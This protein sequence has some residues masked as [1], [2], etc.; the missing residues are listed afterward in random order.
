MS[1]LVKRLRR[2]DEFAVTFE[3]WFHEPAAAIR[4]LDAEEP[5]P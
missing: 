3:D 4:S 1:D 2:A 5:K